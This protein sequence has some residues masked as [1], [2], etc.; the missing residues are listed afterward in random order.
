MNIFVVPAYNEAQ[1]LPRLLADLESRPEIWEGGRLIVV[2]DGSEDGTAEIACAYS[3]PLPIEVIRLTTNQGPGRAFDL[4]FRRA[5][6]IGRASC[7]ERVS[8]TV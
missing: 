3:G 4:G 6:E 5:L 7:R 1:N 8:D 2:D